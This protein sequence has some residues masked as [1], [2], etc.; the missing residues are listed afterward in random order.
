VLRWAAPYVP[1]ALLTLGYLA[2]RYVLF[3]QV[4]REGQL[5]AEGLR[6]FGY[7][8]R[9]HL[10][11]L[12]YGE[13]GVLSRRSMI[14]S[15]VAWLALAS[16]AL[17]GR[18][19]RPV[20]PAAVVAFCLAWLGLG[21]APILVAGYESTRHMYLASIAWAWLLGL[22]LDLL[23]RSGDARLRR[24]AMVAA[25][26]VAAWYLVQQQRS[27]AAWSTAADLSRRMAEDLQREALEAPRGSLLIVGAAPESW[28]YAVPFVAQPPFA[29]EDLTR[30]VLFVMPMRLHARR[31]EWNVLTRETLRHWIEHQKG[32]RV[33][34]LRWDPRTGVM[35]RRTDG[36]APCG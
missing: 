24:L 36:P 10:E 28:E 6:L 2:L 16:V 12:V 35:A 20:H 32:T 17:R 27:V 1:F 19:A 25:A 5:N 4:A 34:A 8:V 14:A 11:R 18:A 15:A 29:R 7:A 22:V 33:V 3:H 26:I 31:P 23:W 30:R 9:N 13:V 21:M